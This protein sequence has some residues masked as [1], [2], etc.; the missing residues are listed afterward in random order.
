MS[1]SA[2]NGSSTT[3]QNDPSQSLDSSLSSLA[4]EQT[5]LKLLV[6]QIQNQDPLNPTDSTQ[7]LGQLTEFSQLEQLIDIHGDLD[8]MNTAQTAAATQQNTSSNNNNGT[9]GTTAS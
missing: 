8:S 9:T 2:V 5:F 6:S 7:F 4:N 3:N 1:V